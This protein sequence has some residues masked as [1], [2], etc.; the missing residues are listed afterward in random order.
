[1]SGIRGKDTAPEFAV[2]RFLHK[3]G[4]RYRLHVNNLPGKPDLV[5]SKYKTVVFVHGCFWHQ[6]Q[7]CKFATKP[8][9]RAEFWESTLSQN[10]SRDRENEKQLIN[11]GWNVIVV[12]ECQLRDKSAS[13]DWVYN[14]ILG[15]AKQ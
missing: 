8:K 2:R 10:S 11:S 12:W 13:L 15:N 14:L 5:F 6:H 9:T 1:M 3:L 4:L 7:N